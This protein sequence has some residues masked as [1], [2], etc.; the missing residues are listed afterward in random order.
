[1]R[2]HLAGLRA[3]CDWLVIHHVLRVN[4]AA[5]VGCLKHVVTEGATPVLTP[6]K[7]QALLH[8]LDT[9][10][11]VALRDRPLL[12]PIGVQLRAGERGRRDG[13]AGLLLAGTA[14]VPAAARE[15]AATPTTCRRNHR[16]E[17]AVE[18]QL[19]SG[20]VVESKA[21]LFRSVDRA[22]AQRPRRQ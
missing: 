13:S 22:G 5:S 7:T 14:G 9:G 15:G 10:P 8:R 3:L 4:P 11:V 18:A 20:G 21:P 12:S 6:A 2:Q 17:E 16:A 19:A 1:M